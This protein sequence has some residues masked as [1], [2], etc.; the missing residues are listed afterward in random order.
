LLEPALQTPDV[1]A[2]QL[3][4][5]LDR[6]TPPLAAPSSAAQWTAEA[7]RIRHRVLN[8]V[9]FHGWPREWVAAPLKAED[10]GSIPSGPGYRVRKIRYEILPGFQ[11]AALLYE[12]ENP[13]GNRPAILNV[14]GHV[15]PPGKSVEYKQKRCV[16]F[17]RD[18]IVA[19]SLEW[20]SY[21]ELGSVENAHWFGAHLDLV[22]ANS[23][24]LFYLAMRKGLDFLDQLP[25]VDRSRL[26]VTGLS[27]GG[28]QTILLSALDGRSRPLPGNTGA[29]LGA[30]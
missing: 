22:G 13:A 4:Q 30:R 2:F 10:L 11:A 24:G 26:G 5:Y 7:V 28:W 6:K 27:G 17:A 8:D 3:R 29:S 16:N 25:G 15:G 9:V 1:V 14:N 23:V 20:F 18:G 12:P 21:G 19:L